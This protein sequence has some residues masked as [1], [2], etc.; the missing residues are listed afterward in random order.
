MWAPWN[1]Q[2]PLTLTI[3]AHLI[4][5]LYYTNEEMKAQREEV[6]CSNSH[7]SWTA[8]ITHQIS[9]YLLITYHIQDLMGSIG[10]PQGRGDRRYHCGPPSI[11]ANKALLTHNTVHWL[12]IICCCLCFAGGLFNSYNRD[13]VS[14]E[15]WAYLGFWPPTS[16][17]PML[18]AS[19]ILIGRQRPLGQQGRHSGSSLPLEEA[20][21]AILTSE[22]LLENKHR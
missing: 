19:T 2:P 20:R 10:I 3:T 13:C 1:S 16:W 11:F 21:A 17:Y 8:R 7:S 14:W 15:G 12:C 22:S 6:I 5:S 4:Q 18:E 9:K